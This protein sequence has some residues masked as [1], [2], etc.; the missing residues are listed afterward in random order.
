M[1]AFFVD[2]S[3]IAKRYLNE[4]GSDWVVSWTLAGAGNLIA[5]SELTII[6]LFSAFARRVREGNLPLNRADALRSNFLLHVESEYLVVKLE[7]QVLAQARNFVTQYPLRTLD[8]I[9]LA[10]AKQTLTMLD[11]QVTFVSADSNLLVVAAAEGF[12]IDNP[13]LHP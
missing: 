4:L 1:S 12:K 2:T 9:Q 7:K 5:I 6:E 10:S 11:E 8:A 13:N 3:A